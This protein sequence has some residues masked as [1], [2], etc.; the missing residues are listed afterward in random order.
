MNDNLCIAFDLETLDIQSSG[1]I[2]SLG[3]VLFDISHSNTFEEL[4][5]QGFNI[6]F[7]Q[8]EQTAK[9][10][11]VST[12]TLNW[13]QQQGEDAAECLN[14]PNQVPCGNLHLYLNRLY[15]ALGVQPNPKVTRWFSR[16][17]FDEKF[18]DSFCQDFNMD[19]PYKFWTWRCARSFLDGI[20]LGSRNEKLEKPVSMVPHNSHHD[21]AFEAYMLQQCYQQQRG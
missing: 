15:Q 20:G 21:A 18:L 9:G 8:T 5:T 2:L 3:V 10:R 6:Y 14:N 19:T 1:V 12:D 11:T 7:D 16:G 4:V 13:W 17:S